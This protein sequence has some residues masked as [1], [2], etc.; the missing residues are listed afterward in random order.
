MIYISDEL[1]HYGVRGMKWGVRKQYPGATGGG[2]YRK[3]VK[4]Y[5]NAFEKASSTQD[6]ADEKWREA[7]STHK[8]LGRTSIGRAIA[9]AQASKG[10]GSAAAK[11]YLKQYGEWEKLQEHADAADKKRKETRKNLGSNW[12]TRTFRTIKYG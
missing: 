12:V 7:K 8:S 11:K 3:R 2:T 6:R 5:S 10:K 4:A 9:V 1:S